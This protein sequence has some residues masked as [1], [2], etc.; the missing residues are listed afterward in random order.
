MILKPAKSGLQIKIKGCPGPAGKIQKLMV[1]QINN[2]IDIRYNLSPFAHP[3][4]ERN[5]FGVCRGV[6]HPLY[7]PASPENLDKFTRKFPVEQS[8]QLC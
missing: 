7:L 5:N 8:R 4:F 6:S 1:Y 2:G 3:F